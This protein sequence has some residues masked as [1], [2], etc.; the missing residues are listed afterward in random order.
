[1][2]R[3]HYATNSYYKTASIML[4][5]APAWVF[6]LEDTVMWICDK[7]PDIK[8]PFLTKIKITRDNEKYDVA[9]YYGDTVNQMFHCL[10]C[11]PVV[12][13]CWSRIETKSIEMGWDKCKELFYKE[14]KDR[15]DEMEKEYEE[16]RKEIEEELV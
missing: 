4:E 14:D 9:E 5:E 8:I 7:L 1:M 15:W 6:I 11:M 2:K 3:W 16:Y 10:V 13:F 12:S